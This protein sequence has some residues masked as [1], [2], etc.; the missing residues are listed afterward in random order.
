[1]PEQKIGTREEWQ[2]ARDE[3]AK[4]EAEQGQRNDEI[5]RKRLDL[6]W[7]VVEKEYEFDSED[8]KKTLAELFDGRS[9]LLAYNIM[10][11]PDYIVGACP[12][13][14]SLGDGLD[15]S[16]VHLNHRDVTLICFSRAPIERLTAYKRRMGWQF[17]YVSTYNTDFP[18]DFGLALTEE[19]A[20]QIPEVKE[21]LDNPP[22]WLQEWSG[23]VGAELKDGLRENPGWIAFA[24][25]NGT[26]Y[27]TYT[28]TAPDPFVAPDYSFLLDRT[29]ELVD[30]VVLQQGLDE[31][32][33]AVNLELRAIRGLELA[34]LAGYIAADVH[35][36]LPVGLHRLVRY[37]VLRRPVD[38]GASLVGL[39]RPEPGEDVVRRAPK[40]KIKG[41]AHLLGH[42]FADELVEVGHRPAA[43][44]E[45]ARRVFLGATRCLHHAV[46]G[47]EREDDQL[48]H[49]N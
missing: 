25:E 9:Q 21:M 40:Q 28:V 35:R 48:S 12:G 41:M 43:E 37:D 46:E 16:L 49:G 45:A 1:M 26:V 10:F 8:G 24:R 17:P 39:L 32:A 42:H 5:K 23:Q 27:H 38:R 44:L 18:F 36:R 33:A 29:P 34:N 11:G 15:G 22:D 4:L 19:Q 14:T 13:C 47:H 2:A 20:Q 30:K 31:V 3:L 6:P 7:V